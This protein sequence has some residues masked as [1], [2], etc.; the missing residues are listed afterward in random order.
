MKLLARTLVGVWVTLGAMAST[1][2]AEAAVIVLTLPEFDGPFADAPP[3]GTFTVGTFSFSIPS[4]EEVIAAAIDGT[5]GNS[6]STSER[7]S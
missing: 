1:T 2:T 7:W 5:F 4:G 3:F 6:Q